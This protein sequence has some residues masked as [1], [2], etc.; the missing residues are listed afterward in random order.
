M[1]SL[2][3]ITINYAYNP[4]IIILNMLLKDIARII[5][6]ISQEVMHQKWRFDEISSLYTGATGMAIHYALLYHQ[7]RKEEYKEYTYNLINEAL[8][9]LP[10]LSYST[11]L[12][13]ISG[14][15]WTLQHLVDIEFFEYKEVESY[16]LK[17][18]KVILITITQDKKRR[19]YDLMHG[20]IG[21]MV[22]LIDIYCF[23][24]I[25]HPEIKTIISDSINYLENISIQDKSNNA[26]YWINPVNGSINIGMAHGISSIIWYLTRIVEEEIVDDVTIKVATSLIIKASN[27]LQRQKIINVESRLQFPTRVYV[28]HQNKK[29]NF[30]LAWCHGDLGVA[31]AFIKAG[32]VLRDSSL[33]NKGIQIAENLSKIKKQDSTI[34]QDNSLIDACFCHGTFGLFFI[35]YILHK[36]T[37]NNKLKE[38]YLYWLNVITSSLQDN[39]E[40]VGLPS[41]SLEKNKQVKWLYEPG[42]LTGMTG[43]ALVL[44]TY[45]LYETGGQLNNKWFKIFL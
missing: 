22:T 41:G 25:A 38:A 40:Y 30:S 34:I 12:S 15:V 32:Q 4:H 5:E 11:S 14:V 45:Y 6:K 2:F 10:S 13:G 44:H 37:G 24:R 39:R 18:K 21:K 33:L 43:Q 35:F 16:L 9:D 20:L 19:N 36:R 23:D 17:L 26:I 28:D 7:T 27:W 42:I 8:N 29:N 1:H 3:Y 31:I